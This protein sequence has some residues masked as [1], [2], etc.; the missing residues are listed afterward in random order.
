MIVLKQIRLTV[1]ISWQGYSKGY[2]KV[3]LWNMNLWIE[4]KCK[5]R[6]YN[7]QTTFCNVTKITISYEI[8]VKSL[9]ECH[10]K[11]FHQTSQL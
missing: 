6:L 2:A 11:I 7:A 4:I 5:N 3:F 9:N 10:S 8:R 1:E